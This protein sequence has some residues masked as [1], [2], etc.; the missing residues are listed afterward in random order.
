M[1]LRAFSVS[2]SALQRNMLY[3]IPDVREKYRLEYLGNLKSA[4]CASWYAIA[5]TF[6]D[7]G[8]DIICVACSSSWFTLQITR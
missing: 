7:L 8:I 3:S 2:E 5:A 4:R 1:R 6:R